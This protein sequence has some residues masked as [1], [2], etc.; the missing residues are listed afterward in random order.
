MRVI[1]APPLSAATQIL[2]SRPG[3]GGA[4]SG[5]SSQISDLQERQTSLWAAIQAMN[6]PPAPFVTSSMERIT[7]LI[8][9]AEPVLQENLPVEPL[10]LPPLA[11]ESSTVEGT[12]AVASRI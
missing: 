6:E 3:S 7:R 12:P 5:T 10:E 9:K 2:R 11:P 4:V 1:A 8:E